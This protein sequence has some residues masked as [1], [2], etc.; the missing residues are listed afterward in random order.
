[1]KK[2]LIIALA[3]AFAILPASMSA[4]SQTPTESNTVDLSGV[5]AISA[6]DAFAVGA[7]GGSALIEQFNG[8]TWTVSPSPA[9]SGGL[10]GV[11]A[12]SANNVWAVGGSESTSLIEH[13]NGT[14]WTRVASAVEAPAGPA[15]MKRRWSSTGTGRSGPS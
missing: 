2:R 11:A 4:A 6:T 12:T 5:A 13:Y 9:L 3:T 14:E 15:S 1:M 10:R 8:S 7:T